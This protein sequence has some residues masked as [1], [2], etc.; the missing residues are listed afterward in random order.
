MRRHSRILPFLIRR[1]GAFDKTRSP[2]YL[3]EFEGAAHLA[4]TDLNPRFHDMITE[5][6]VAFFDRHLKGDKAA[7]PTRSMSRVAAMRVK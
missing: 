4:W 1:D 2:A 3:V 6:S 5:Y 7:D